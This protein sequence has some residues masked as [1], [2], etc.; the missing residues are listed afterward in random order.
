MTEEATSGKNKSN[1]A[2]YIAIIGLIVIV[3]A[4]AGIK[5]EYSH[6]QQVQKASDNKQI[7]IVSKPQ[8]ASML[9]KDGTYTAQG[10]YIVHIGPEHI[11]V[12]VTLKK[13]HIIDSTVTSEAKFGISAHMQSVFI[14][15]YKQY[16]LGKDISSIHLGKISSSSLTPNGFNDALSKIESQAKI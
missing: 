3:I 9:Y 4:A 10:D 11:L 14:A 7:S 16:V 12:T 2:R 1:N 8:K 13:D 5:Y 15:N 6:K